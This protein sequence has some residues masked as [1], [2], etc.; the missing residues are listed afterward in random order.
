MPRNF[1]NGFYAGLV[2]ALILGVYLARLWRPERQVQ[3]HS[4]HLL[5]QIEKKN[6]KAVGE[7]IRDDY[8]DRW[9]D[10]RALLLERLREVFRALPNARI[11]ASAPAVRIDDGHGFWSAKIT[12]SGAG[13]FADLIAARVNSLE[14]PFELEWRR[15]ATWPWDWKLVSIRN[16]A[17]EISDEGR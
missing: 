14:A 10:D 3:L 13:E 16:P 1:R 5:A 9:G 11:E 12:I 6:W 8:Q 17:L 2:L 15:G 7:F 4:T